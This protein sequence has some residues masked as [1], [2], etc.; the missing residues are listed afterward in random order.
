MVR[1]LQILHPG[2]KFEI[3]PIVA[4]AMGRVPKGPGTY[5]KMFGF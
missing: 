1:N 5:L 4:V 3:V 2:F